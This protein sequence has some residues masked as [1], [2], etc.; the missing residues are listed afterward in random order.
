MKKYYNDLIKSYF[1]TK[2]ILKGDK[3]FY[4]EKM[5]ISKEFKQFLDNVN[6]RNFYFITPYN[7][8]SLFLPGWYNRSVLKLL[9]W[10]L[11]I[12]N[13]NYVNCRTK[14]TDYPFENGLIIFNTNIIFVLFLQLI[15]GQVA[16]IQY[17]NNTCKFIINYLMFFINYIKN[18]IK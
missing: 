11:T 15:F 7:P 1:N 13:C 4:I 14:H 5:T 17:K 9:V 10:L 16:I 6:Y 2:F 8:C 18:S 12:L 3:N